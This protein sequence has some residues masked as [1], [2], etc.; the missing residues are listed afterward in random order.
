MRKRY[1]LAFAA[2]LALE[3]YIGMFVRD[4]FIRPYAGDMLVTLLL[5]CLAKALWPDR[6]P[7]LPVF[8]FAAAVEAAQALQLTELLGL[9]GTLPGLLLGSTFDWH[10][11]FC[12]A[13]GCLLFAAVTRLH[14]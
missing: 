8:L 3:I 9:E 10:D 14:R 5:C 4:A 13:L 7:E 12:Y 6:R 2:L 1:A 11:I